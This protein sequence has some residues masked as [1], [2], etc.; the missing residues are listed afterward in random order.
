MGAKHILNAQTHKLL[1]DARFLTAL[2]NNTAKAIKSGAIHKSALTE[3]DF[4]TAKAIFICT[5]ENMIY[6]LKPLTTEGKK[7]ANKLRQIL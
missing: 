1:N 5:L 7:T 4:S 2:N 6:D 3:N